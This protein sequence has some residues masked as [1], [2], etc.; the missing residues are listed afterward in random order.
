MRGNALCGF[1]WVYLT[2]DLVVRS[3]PLYA[4]LCFRDGYSFGRPDG[5]WEWLMGWH[6]YLS[7]LSFGLS[8]GLILWV[9]WKLHGFIAR[10]IHIFLAN[11]ITRCCEI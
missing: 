8:L 2:F 3:R 4:T 9:A 5:C 1:F 7:I 6:G 10:L 11:R